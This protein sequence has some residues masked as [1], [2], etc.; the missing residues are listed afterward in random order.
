M[1]IEPKRAK[2][3]P[4]EYL[5]L[6]R[7]AE[8]KHE[9]VNGEIV[10]MAGASREHILI[11]G[12]LTRLVNQALLDSDCET[13]AAE[14]RVKVWR[15]GLYTYPDLVVACPPIQFEDAAVDT[16]LN[17]VVI[18]EVLSPST[19]AYD[20]GRKFADYR[21]L[22]SLREYILVAQDS[23]HIER[24]VR[25]GDFWIFSERT[26]L[27]AVLEIAAIGCRLALRDIYLRVPVS[28]DGEP[29]VPLA[30]APPGL[31]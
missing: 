1:T 18:I 14:M 23:P 27:D 22:A 20:R 19:E 16:L 7:G 4:A 26:G 15:T 11:T 10:A 17:P 13:Y 2:Y 21:R 29:T 31:S 24:F 12:N 6:E 28:G 25:Q 5:T 3:T 9:Y 8:T 30:E